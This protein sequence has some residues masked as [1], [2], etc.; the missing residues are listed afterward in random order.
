MRLALGLLLALIPVFA[1]NLKPATYRVSWGEVTYRART[2]L[3]AWTGRNKAI[4]GAVTLSQAGVLG[5]KLCVDLSAWDSGNALRDAHTRKMFRVERYPEACFV[6]RSLA[7][8]RTGRFTVVGDLF[9]NSQKGP[10]TLSGTLQEDS[11]KVS[12]SL[13]GYLSLRKWR[14]KPPRLLGLEV[15]DRVDVEIDLE[16]E[17][18][19]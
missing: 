10:W 13:E 3:S 1:L 8:L 2:V 6:P 17:E 18:I 5:G 7:L 19:H 16:L 15:E 14:L 4:S 11:G 9:L 12:L